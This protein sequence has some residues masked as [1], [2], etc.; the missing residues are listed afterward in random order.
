VS[1][2]LEISN[3]FC[4]LV[5]CAVLNSLCFQ[6]ATQH[7][8]RTS[9]GSMANTGTLYRRSFQWRAASGQARCQSFERHCSRRHSLA[10]LP[11]PHSAHLQ[12][13]LL[14]Y[15][16]YGLPQL[17]RLSSTVWPIIRS[18]ECRCALVHSGGVVLAV[19]HCLQS[20]CSIA[21]SSSVPLPS[22]L[23]PP[24]TR[25]RL[26]QP[27]FI[28]PHYQQPRRNASSPCHRQSYFALHRRASLP[29][30]PSLRDRA[31]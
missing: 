15:R 6:T 19:A 21:L 20:R 28:P 16:P 22:L 31:W 11:S 14:D 25:P 29:A 12:Q 9:A 4:I 3:N 24:T 17:V 23:L 30:R 5:N 10:V 26:V 27:Y 7:C 8:A 2:A 1:R 13:P 18:P